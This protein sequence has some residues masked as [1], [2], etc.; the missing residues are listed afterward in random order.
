MSIASKC[1]SLMSWTVPRPEVEQL[2]IGFNVQRLVRLI[3]TLALPWHV[4]LTPFVASAGVSTGVRYTK[5][6]GQVTA[7][8]LNLDGRNQ[9]STATDCGYPSIGLSAAPGSPFLKA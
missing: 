8:N 4:G 3:T 7:C 6:V 9:Q 2:S 5:V 1:T